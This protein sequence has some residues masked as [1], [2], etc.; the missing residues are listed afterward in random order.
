[1]IKWSEDA[2]KP[3]IVDSDKKRYG[4]LYTIIEEKETLNSTL[5]QEVDR[6]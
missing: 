3:K 4:Q 6:L 2:E 5:Q 1:M